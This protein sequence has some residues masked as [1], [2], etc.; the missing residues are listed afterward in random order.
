MFVFKR[1]ALAGCLALAGALAFACSGSGNPYT[2]PTPNPPNP[3]NPNPPANNLPV[4]DSITFQGTRL[5]EP[6]DFADVAETVPVVA[7]VHDDETAAD[8]LEY[9]WTATAGTFSGSGAN[10]TW[11]AP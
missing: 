4:I 8:Q 11:T 10:V 7:K 2:P 6:A 1:F 9:Q 3:P 5:K